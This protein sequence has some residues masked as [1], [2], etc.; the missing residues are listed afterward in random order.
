[1]GHLTRQ[2][3]E[4][5]VP[6]AFRVLLNEKLRSSFGQPSAFSVRAKTFESRGFVGFY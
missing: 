2:P 1:M 3:R 6:R 4:I 5:K